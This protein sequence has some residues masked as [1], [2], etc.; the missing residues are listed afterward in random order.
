MRRAADI[1]QLLDS[2]W[3]YIAAALTVFIAAVASIHAVLYKRDSRAAVLWVGFI[4]LVPLLG[5]I[6]YLMLGINRLKRHAMSLRGEMERYSSEPSIPPCAPG[7][8][9]ELLPPDAWHL[10]GLAEL[11]SRVVSQRLVPGNSIEPLVN[12][13]EA[14]PAMLAAIDAAQKSV[15]FASYIFDNDE[16]GGKFVEALSRATARGVEVRVLVDATGA[17]YSFP[18]IVG[19]LR[20][21]GVTVARFLPTVPW[22]PIFINL[23]NHRKLLVVDGITGFTGGM[24]I[25]AGHLVRANPKRAVQDL[26][27]RV[28]GPVVAHLQEAFAADWFFTTRESLRGETWFP[29]LDCKGETI[30]R[31]LSD[32]PDEDFEKLRWTILGALSTAKRS[33]LIVTPYFLPDQAVISAL[34]VAAMRGVDVDILLPEKNNLS[35]MNWATAAILWQVL[36]RGCRVWL[37]PPPFDHSKLMLVDGHWSLVGSGNW[38]ARSFRLNFEFNVECYGRELA[39]RLETLAREK[40]KQARQITLKDVDSRSFPVKVRD[41]VARLFMPFL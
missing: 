22:R 9:Q 38:D 23:R 12:G 7:K 16:I 37:T 26:H 25:R 28:E 33:V 31:G 1:L 32:G 10:C 39:S 34:N 6:L 18:P 24:N 4:W 21:E 14:Y 17:R 40:Q 5:A 27:F 36:E 29:Q 41:G 20:R 3:H 35:Y 8:L 30:A 13:E 2:G 11:V 19:R 15:G